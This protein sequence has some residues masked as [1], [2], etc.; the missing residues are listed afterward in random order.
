MESPPV[1]HRKTK[2]RSP[3]WEVVAGGEF[4]VLLC[5]LSTGP[6]GQTG[7]RCALG[8]SR[9]L[10]T[11]CALFPLDHPC[12]TIANADGGVCGGGEGI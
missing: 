1:Q 11:S 8:Q 9:F 3:L 12:R 2:Q 6:L 4:S 10:A 5:V 7:P